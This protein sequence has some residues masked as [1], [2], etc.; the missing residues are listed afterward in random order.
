MFVKEKRKNRRVVL[1]NSTGNFLLKKVYHQATNKNNVLLKCYKV[2]KNN[3]KNEIMIKLF[4]GIIG[5]IVFREL[6]INKQFGYVAKSKIELF[7]N[8]F[9][10]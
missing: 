4:N 3:Y 7:D 6:R 8:L 5:N 10:S 2:G 1:K 9:V